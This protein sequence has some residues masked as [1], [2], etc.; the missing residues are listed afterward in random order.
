MTESGI[1]FIEPPEANDRVVA[2]EVTGELTAEDMTTM[3]DRIQAI[4]DRGEKALL[5][6]DM[7]GYDGWEFGVATEKLKH[8]GMLWRAFD[9]YAI[10]G[11]DRWVDVW[12][13]IVDPLTPQQI[14]SF[15]PESAD[16]AW[17]W[18]LATGATEASEPTGA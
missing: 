10:V 16:D 8:M 14:R 7:H 17:G 3:I 11:A 13:K 12:V 2:V 1:R 18:L 9:R 5:Y 4:V 6:V 15:A